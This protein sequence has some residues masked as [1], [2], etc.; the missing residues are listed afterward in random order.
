MKPKF[1]TV[2][3]RLGYA[4]LA[5][6]LLVHGSSVA[7]AQDKAGPQD[8]P[9]QVIKDERALNLLKSMSDTL[10]KAQTLGFKLRGL[11]PIEAPTGQF[12]NLLASSRVV[13]QR[14]DKLF[15]EARGDL[16]PSDIYFNGKTVT[17]VGREKHFYAQ[18]EAAASTIDAAIEKRFPASTALASFADLIVSDPYA[19]LT[20]DLT[21]ALVVGQSTIGGVLT[22]H[23]A[24][25]ARGIDWEIWI[26]ACDKLPRLM[27]VSYRDSERQPTFTVELS[28][29]ML[30]APVP[31]QTFNADIPKDAVRIEFK[32]H[33]LPQ[34]K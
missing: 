18:R 31:A 3:R 17:A 9:D 14:P 27:V 16:F 21:N 30:D 29:W 4:V 12:I 23:L 7:I 22:D 10:A 6:G 11:V 34:T 2:G 5:A 13:I 19:S 32:P 8:A 15:V 24:F 26:G 33:G 20:K 28:D 25:T 1:K